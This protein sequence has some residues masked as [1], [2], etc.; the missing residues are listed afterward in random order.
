MSAHENALVVYCSVPDAAVGKD[1]ARTIV[2]EG[3]CACVNK[4]PS[5]TS[6]YIYNGEFNEDSEELLVI[7]THASH[8]KQ[9]Q[10]RIIELHPYDV[11]EIIA[12]EIVSG[13]ETYLQWL[14]DTLKPL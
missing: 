2:Q 13:S 4:I 3:L 5:V 7:K 14:A 9:L 6:Y 8:L 1:I 11:P 10:D 12:T